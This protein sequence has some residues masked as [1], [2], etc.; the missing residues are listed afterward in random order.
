MNQDQLKYRAAAILLFSTVLVSSAVLIEF[1][2]FLGFS[3]NRELLYPII[4]VVLLS[5]VGS[6]Q[7]LAANSETA[8][9]FSTFLS[10]RG[11][12]LVVLASAIA[13]AAFLSYSNIF[14]DEYS[15]IQVLQSRPLANLP[16]FLVNYQKIAGNYLFI[17]PPLSLLL[18]DVG[19]LI[20]PSIYGPR[21]VSALF[22]TASVLVVYFLIRDLGYPKTAVLASAVYGLVPH[23]ALYLTLAL[24]DGI[25]FFFGITSLWLFVK[26]LK[27]DSYGLSL[28]S[29]VVL[30]LAL[31]TK[32]W[33]PFFL[34]LLAIVMALFVFTKQRIWN[35]LVLFMTMASVS[36]A[37]FLIWGLINPPAFQH[38]VSA[39]WDEIL[40]FLNPA[41]YNVWTAPPPTTPGP[42]SNL[43]SF[44]TVFYPKIALGS[45]RIITYPEL[46]AQVPLWIPLCVVVM[47]IVGVCIML[48][49]DTR[50]GVASVVWLAVPFLLMLPY[51]RDLRYLVVTAPVY[52]LSASVASI[53]PR[54]R[55]TTLCLQSILLASLIVSLVIMFPVSNQ[56][57][58][59]V[60][61]ASSRLQSLGLAEG[62]V[63]TNVPPNLLTYYLP[64][65]QAF[66]LPSM[67]DPSTVVAFL[68]QE[69]IEA[70]VLLHNERG[71]W[72]GVSPAVSQAIKGQFSG[73]AEGGPSAFSW[74][75]LFYSPVNN[76]QST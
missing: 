67:T 35:R 1:G 43:F 7:W 32:A 47:C 9:R 68:K 33:L 52:A 76:T 61:E 22:S 45:L 42:S 6:G 75:E 12:L 24:T 58:G 10:S 3:L 60:Q 69:G 65:L 41:Q 14:P 48:R 39:M 54:S 21:L 23:T 53:V 49:R 34:F 16:S 30:A 18:M 62:K 56:M 36:V 8:Q 74:Y 57:Y 20:V 71:A 29:G 59:G 4:V 55:R 63:L 70:V 66:S 17:H 72:P 25:W 5:L 31:W 26:A 40:I 64:G 44:L 38:S 37:I 27:K 19:Y 11:L 28:A 15:I 13:R 2:A 46:V 51:F 50:F 73:Y